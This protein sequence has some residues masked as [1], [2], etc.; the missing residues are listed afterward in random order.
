MALLWKKSS[1]ISD[2][3][4]Q[5]FNLL[6]KNL[7]HA[8]DSFVDDKFPAIKN[9]LMAWR[10]HVELKETNKA[11]ILKADIPGVDKKDLK[12]EIS[13]D[14]LTISGERKSETKSANH[15]HH[16]TERFHGK[17]SRSF[18]L[19]DDLVDQ[20]KIE[21]RFENGVLTVIMQKKPSNGGKKAAQTT[22]IDIK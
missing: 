13:H 9:G 6:Q 5:I 14:V 15:T 21:A 3:A 19:P 2:Y 16:W 12:V 20:K 1:N 7:T 10:P 11:F 22:S 8:V 17:F 18:S 4:D